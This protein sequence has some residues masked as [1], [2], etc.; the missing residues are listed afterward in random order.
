MV[1][2]D[3][4]HLL[5]AVSICSDARDEVAISSCHLFAVCQVSWS[6]YVAGV[7]GISDDNV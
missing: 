2:D 3:L 7:D 5:W 6:G 1:V 4:T